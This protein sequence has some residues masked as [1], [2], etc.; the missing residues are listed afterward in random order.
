VIIPSSAAPNRDAQHNT[1]RAIH[2]THYACVCVFVCVCVSAPVC[3]GTPLFLCFGKLWVVWFAVCVSLLVAFFGSATARRI[4]T[5]F[6]LSFVSLTCFVGF[7][8][9]GFLSRAT[10]A[11]AKNPRRRRNARTRTHTPPYTRRRAPQRVFGR[12]EK[13]RCVGKVG[14]RERPPPPP[15]PPLR[16]SLFP[17]LTPAL[18]CVCRCVSVSVSVCVR[19]VPPPCVCVCAPFCPVG[20]R[21]P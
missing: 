20:P 5:A 7:V 14:F 1:P 3:V 8:C 2:Y 21:P 12:C 13:G 6:R 17:L 18:V 10:S 16:S 11:A 9:L 19:S 15:P 4:H